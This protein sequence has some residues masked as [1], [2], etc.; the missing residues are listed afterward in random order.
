MVILPA[1][2]LVIS[3]SCPLAEPVGRLAKSVGRLAKSV[4]RL[5]IGYNISHKYLIFNGFIR[6]ESRIY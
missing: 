6:I 1:T 4:G 3:Y 2:R 5:A